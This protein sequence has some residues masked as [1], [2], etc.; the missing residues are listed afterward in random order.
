MI[1]GTLAM[2]LTCNLKGSG[3]QLMHTSTPGT[4][5]TSI[6]GV[7]R[8]VA[9]AAA[10]TGAAEGVNVRLITE[11]GRDSAP[12]ILDQVKRE[13]DKFDTDGIKISDTSRTARYIAMHDIKGELVAACA[14]M[15]SASLLDT[16]WIEKQILTDKPKCVFFD[17]NIGVKQKNS[18]I[19]ASKQ[20]DAVVGFEPASVPKASW[21]VN[22]NL[23]VFPNS[24][25]D[26]ITPNIY[27]LDALYN[28]FKDKDLFDVD[29]WFPVIDSLQISETFRTSMESLSQTVPELSGLNS[30]GLAQKAFHLLPYIPNIFVKNGSKGVLIFQLIDGI[31]AVQKTIPANLKTNGGGTVNS[32]VCVGKNDRGILVQHFPAEKLDENAVVSVTGAG[33]TFCGV[34]VAETARN[35]NWLKD[36]G[37]L[38]L[39]VIDRAQ[40]S[41]AL[42]VQSELAV[43]PAITEL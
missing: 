38:K 3:D 6:G 12:S 2:D 39:K 22:A 41:A 33:D 28:S 26:I 27:E 1:V 40:M 13:Y 23:D 34:L 35:K 17:G 8:N 25:V 36:A 29:H 15:E 11:L 4:V 32:R 7:G 19:N 16:K 24:S 20:V 10:Y 18:V 30:S 14:D 37:R 9:L 42:T 43:N 21:L 5:D 31:G